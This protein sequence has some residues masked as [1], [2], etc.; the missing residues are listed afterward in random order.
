MLQ[1]FN[2]K[3]AEDAKINLLLHP[4]LELSFHG[5]PGDEMINQVEIKDSEHLCVALPL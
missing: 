2:K 3:K 4:F 1:P 5:L